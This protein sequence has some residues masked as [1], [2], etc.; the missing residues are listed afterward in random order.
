VQEVAVLQ[1]E[2]RDPEPWQELAV[3]LALRRAAAT[4]YVDGLGGPVDGVLAHATTDALVLELPDGDQP[5]H[6]EVF[7]I[8]LQRVIGIRASFRRVDTEVEQRRRVQDNPDLLE[9]IRAAAAPHTGDVR[10]VGHDLV[11]GP[12]PEVVARQLGGEVPVA[13]VEVALRILIERGELPHEPLC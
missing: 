6:G 11:R 9:R 12:A 10:R 3:E 13:D 7:W 1:V 4:V 5:E 2:A 8:P